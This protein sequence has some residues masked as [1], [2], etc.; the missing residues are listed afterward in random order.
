MCEVYDL[1]SHILVKYN[2]HV[3]TIYIIIAI[4]NGTEMIIMCEPWGKSFK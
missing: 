2:G 1:D 4:K 3:F